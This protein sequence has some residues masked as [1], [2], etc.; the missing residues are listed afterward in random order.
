MTTL[1]EQFAQAQADYKALPE[2]SSTTKLKAYALA[3]QGSIGDVEGPQP[4]AT[5]DLRRSKWDAW[6]ALKGTS[7]ETAQEKYIELVQEFSKR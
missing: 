5:D 3:K 1:Q 6:N 4:A 7:K 2:L